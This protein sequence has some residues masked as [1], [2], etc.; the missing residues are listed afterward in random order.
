MTHPTPQEDES[1]NEMRAAIEAIL[2]E[3]LDSDFYSQGSMMVSDAVDRIIALQS[4]PQPDDMY[5]K[6]EKMNT[7]SE[8]AQNIDTSQ[9]VDS[10]DVVEVNHE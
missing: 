2:L 4:P 10:S 9:P 7:S 3:L 5:K 1:R 6:H 8:H